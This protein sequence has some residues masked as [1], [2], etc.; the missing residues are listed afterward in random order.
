MMRWMTASAVLAFVLLHVT[1]PAVRAGETLRGP[2]ARIP[3]LPTESDQSIEFDLKAGE[4]GPVELERGSRFLDGVEIEIRIP[5][6]VRSYA[7]SFGV[8]ILLG[9]RISADRNHARVSGETLLFETLPRTRRV[10]VQVPIHPDHRLRAS[11]DT[12]LARR[13]VDGGD[14]PLMLSI[15]PVMKGVPSAARAASFAVKIRTLFREEGAARVRLRDPAGNDITE[16]FDDYVEEITLTIG[17]HAIEDPQQEIVL[18]T[19]LHQIRL[20]S[21]RY[22][23]RTE[24]FGVERGT[25]QTVG[26]TVEEETSTVSIDAPLGVEMFVNGE[27]VDPLDREL[28]LAPGDYTVLFRFGEYTISRSLK[29][30][31]KRDYKVSLSLD[32]LIEED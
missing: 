1:A 25:T 9:A 10:F 19:G 5:D 23:D 2:M 26:I 30:E 17:D 11:A 13:R 18:P 15:R 20:Q 22:V 24:T 4:I 6:S 32:I 3:K 8:Y 29:I 27:R 7:D 21:E 31:P 16:R 14:F 28:E 12:F